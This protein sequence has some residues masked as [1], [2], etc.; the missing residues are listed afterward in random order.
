MKENQFSP[1]ES[2][3]QIDSGTTPF[4]S[5]GVTTYNRPDLLKQTLISIINQT[6]MDFEVIIGNDNPQLPISSETLGI[7]DPRIRIF[8]WEVNLGEN[9][10]MNAL[11]GK[12]KAKYFTWISDDDLISPDYLQKIR[13]VISV[14]D[15]PDCV[16]TSVKVL[17]GT[18]D[19]QKKEISNVKMISLS[20]HQFLG[21]YFSGKIK[22]MATS[23]CFN[24]QAL[25]KIGMVESL[26]N[27]PVNIM[28]EYWLIVRCG[29]LDKILYIKNPLVF[30][31]AHEESFSTKNRDFQSYK[32]AGKNLVIKSLTVLKLP[33]FR[34]DI[35]HNML[36]ILKIASSGVVIISSRTNQFISMGE[37]N[38]YYISL[39]K[40]IET[41]PALTKN[42][43]VMTSKWVARVWLIFWLWPLG[44]FRSRAPQG[45]VRIALIIRSFISG[46]QQY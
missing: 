1:A 38:R 33:Q 45:L 11:V 41:V 40:Q 15:P 16:F 23:G 43:Q 27:A 10:N 7:W 35:Y 17:R 28:A 6:F 8:N 36:G 34:Q 5:I 26:C 32:I 39:A 37:L 31:R 44:A 4:F 21:N 30:F 42:L 13:S 9:G 14:K 46:E 19:P 18:M 3:N 22:I 25:R 12:S 29:L 24:L 20:G 2:D